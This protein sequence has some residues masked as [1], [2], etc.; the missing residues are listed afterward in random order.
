MCL[1]CGFGQCRSNTSV[2]CICDPGFS[3]SR[4]MYAFPANYECNFDNPDICLP[5]NTRE[6]V[7]F[8]LY[9]ST[10]LLDAVLLFLLF[11]G[12][13]MKQVLRWAVFIAG[14]VM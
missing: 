8:G 6:D 10:A 11:W 4:E 14:F 2:I 12:K 5:C 7:V 13:N 9:L 1:D 3:Q